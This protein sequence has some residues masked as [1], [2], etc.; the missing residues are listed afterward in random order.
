MLGIAA[1][2]AV[3]IFIV[4]VYKTANGTGR[5]G[6]LWALLTG[7]VGFGIQLL[8]PMAIGLVMGIY[9]IA[10]GSSIEEME[11]AVN[12]WSLLIGLP[13]IVLSIAGVWL[14]MNHVSKVPDEPATASAPPPPPP[15]FGQ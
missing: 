4:Q 11:A 8:L 2:I 10:T 15:T 5:N 7:V 3:I 6:A 14:I 13:C 1:L 12:G 9:Y